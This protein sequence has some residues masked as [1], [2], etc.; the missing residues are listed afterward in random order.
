[1]GH[2]GRDRLV[3]EARL[4]E[5]YAGV[6]ATRGLKVAGAPCPAPEA[7]LALVRREGSESSRLATLDH[8]MSCTECRSEFDLLR[9]VE[10]A[11]AE[12]GSA[13]RPGRRKWMVPAALAASVLLALG[14]GRLAIPTAPDTDVVRSGADAGV[15]LLA[16]PPEARAGSPM[17][18]AWHPTPGAARYRLEVLSRDGEVA[19][20]AETLDTSITLQS[21]AD[22]APGDYQWWV[23][24]ALP[25]NTARSA[26]RPLRLTAQ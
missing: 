20:E 6:M 23:G 16:P 21:A 12:L 13:A 1:M 25:G 9:S 3:S 24:A 10:V 14:I 19:L 15:T 26:L 7:V 2:G 8:V 18:F 4:R 22:L 5:I 17:L 11:H